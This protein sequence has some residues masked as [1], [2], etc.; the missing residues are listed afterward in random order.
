V[1]SN[2]QK[3]DPSPQQP[4][5]NITNQKTSKEAQLTDRPIT[6]EDLDY[7]R[8]DLFTFIDNWKLSIISELQKRKTQKLN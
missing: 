1:K 2:H 6:Y 3:K 5:Q 7:L 8:Q 4:Q